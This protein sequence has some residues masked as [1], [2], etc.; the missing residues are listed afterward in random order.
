MRARPVA[1]LHHSG[2]HLF[3]LAHYHTLQG[4]SVLRKSERNILELTNGADVSSK[5]K[6]S[7]RVFIRCGFVQVILEAQR[8][9]RKEKFNFLH[10]LCL[11]YQ[12]RNSVDDLMPHLR[13]G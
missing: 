4:V 9:S 11:V 10:W 12:L 6:L 1:V 8:H 13:F 5:Q 3:L 2:T 7:I